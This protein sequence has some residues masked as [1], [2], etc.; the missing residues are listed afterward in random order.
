[1]CSVR[2]QHSK[3]G[4]T[5]KNIKIFYLLHSSYTSL[6]TV[7]KEADQDLEEQQNLNEEFAKEMANIAS[8][9]NYYDGQVA[10]LRTGLADL[11]TAEPWKENLERLQQEIG[12]AAKERAVAEE[13]ISLVVGKLEDVTHNLSG[14]F[15]NKEEEVDHLK[16]EV[17]SRI[18]S[19][20]YR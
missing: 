14:L 4:K 7:Q 3:T 18:A 19:L 8:A 12:I 20:E 2:L 11:S 15:E 16:T 6:E 5:N 17:L 9:V 1:M 13:K 10:D